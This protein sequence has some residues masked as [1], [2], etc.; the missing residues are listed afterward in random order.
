MQYNPMKFTSRPFRF[1]LVMK[2]TLCFLAADASLAAADVLLIKSQESVATV[3]PSPAAA[4]NAEHAALAPADS[5]KPECRDVVVVID[6]G[7]GVSSQVTRRVCRK[8][9]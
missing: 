4:R 6:E 7:Y 2:I 9:L 5:T 3:N 1:A 8:A